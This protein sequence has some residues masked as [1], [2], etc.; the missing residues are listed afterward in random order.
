MD[1]V[2]GDERFNFNSSAVD[3]ARNTID[4]NPIFQSYSVF[5]GALVPS[6]VRSASWYPDVIRCTALDL[7]FLS[8]CVILGYIFS[9]DAFKTLLLGKRKFTRNCFF[10]G[11][12]LHNAFYF[13][14]VSLLAADATFRLCSSAEYRWSGMCLSAYVLGIVQVSRHIVHF[15][16]LFLLKW[17]NVP[18]FSIHH[19]IV[20]YVYASGCERQRCAFWG[21]LLALCEI[22]NIPLTVLDGLNSLEPK[23]TGFIH[24]LCD[25]IFKFSYVT[26]R[27]VLYPVMLTSFYHDAYSHHAITWESVGAVERWGYPAAAMFVFTLSVIWALPPSARKTTP[28]KKMS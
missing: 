7:V 27:L 3:T 15:P 1:V 18:L 20:I 5:V 8:L 19:A 24:L 2:L 21:S 25:A 12:V 16:Y 9:H 23:A 10:Y 4:Q 13:T 11:D 22:S 6:A 17:E 28:P 14:L 26:F